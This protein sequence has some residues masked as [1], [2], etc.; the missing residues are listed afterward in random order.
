MHACT[1]PYLEVVVLPLLLGL[2][3]ETR[4]AAQVLLAHRLVD[5]RTAL[6]AFAVVVRRVGPPVGLHLD[7]AQ[8]HILHRRRHARHLPRDVG[9]AMWHAAV[10]N[11]RYGRMLHIGK[12]NTRHHRR[13][14]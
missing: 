8:N 1:A 12:N 3:V 10:R 13:L 5:G 7:K 4:Q 11:Q 6:D 2:E 14:P 9:P